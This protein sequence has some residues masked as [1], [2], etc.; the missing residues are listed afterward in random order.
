MGLSV[1]ART[2]LRRRV[3]RLRVPTSVADIL[4]PTENCGTGPLSC[5]SVWRGHPKSLPL[6]MSTPLQGIRQSQLVSLVLLL[7]CSFGM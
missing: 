4:M 3:R 6:I 7:W 1:A 2:E 5:A